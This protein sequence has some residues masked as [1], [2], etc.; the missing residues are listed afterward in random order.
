MK[1][2]LSTLLNILIIAIISISSI[3][4]PVSSV[5]QK[6]SA[7]PS[8]VKLKSVKV[9]SKKVIRVKWKKVK[10]AKGYQIKIS[11]NKKFTK[12]RKIDVNKNACTKKIKKLKANTKYYVKVRAFVKVNGRRVF[13]KWSKAIFSRTKSVSSNASKKISSLKW[14]TE[15]CNYVNNLISNSSNYFS[16]Y[17]GFW[18][19]NINDDKIPELYYDT[20]TG[21]GGSGIITYSNGNVVKVTMGNSSYI[22]YLDRKNLFKYSGGH[23]DEY[24]DKIYTIKNGKFVLLYDG[25]YGAEDNSKVQID[26]NGMPIYKYYWNGKEATKNKYT[27]MLNDKFDKSKAVKPLLDVQAYNLNQIISAINNY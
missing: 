26:K 22:E 16:K 15:Y 14:K 18:L 3:S 6:T 21:V 27:S 17:A 4:M 13:G 1:T 9:V 10:K 12:A 7:K 2:I 23:M 20:G 5:K 24:Y 8:R 19:V 25:E 11:K